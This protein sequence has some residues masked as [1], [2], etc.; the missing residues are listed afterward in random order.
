LPA[1]PPSRFPVGNQGRTPPLLV[2]SSRTRPAPAHALSRHDMTPARLRCSCRHLDRT[3]TTASRELR[4]TPCRAPRSALTFARPLS[5][6][7]PSKP[8]ASLMSQHG[9]ST[10]WADASRRQKPFVEHL[11]SRAPAPPL[12]FQP[13]REMKPTRQASPGN[14]PT[15]AE[16]GQTGPT[17]RHLFFLADWAGSSSREPIQALLLFLF[18]LFRN[19]TQLHQ[20]VE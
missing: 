20:S 14:P 8:H 17:P 13:S 3:A 7:G 9:T 11:R 16:T 4:R 5:P 19:S 2:A 6:A 18:L 15:W 12:C 10:H 1:Q